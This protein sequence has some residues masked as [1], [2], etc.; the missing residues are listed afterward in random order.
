MLHVYYK[1][2]AGETT[3]DILTDDTYRHNPESWFDHQGDNQWIT[4]ELEKQ[5]IK[6]ID[7]SDVIGPNLL[8]HPHYGAYPPSHL[9]GGTKA[10]ILMNNEPQYYYNGEYFGENCIPWIQK[11]AETKDVYIHPVYYMHLVEPFVAHIIN[12]N[13]I[14]TTEDEFF[15]KYLQFKDWEG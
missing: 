10:L 7:K 5:I 11:I 15:K 4:G 13:S 14:V 12:D 1:Y 9:A 3:D 6:D 8:I 2:F